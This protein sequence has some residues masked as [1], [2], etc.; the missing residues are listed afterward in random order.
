MNFRFEV[1]WEELPAFAM[2][3]W[4]TVWLSG[5]GMALATVTGVLFVL[6]LV[7]KRRSLQIPAQALVDAGR[8]I[9][10]L[11]LIYLIFYG[12]PAYGITLD[13][14][15][16]ALLSLVLYNTAY[17]A[18]IIRSAWENLP[19]GQ[20]EAARAF[21]YSGFNLLRR[22]TLPQILITASPVLGNQFIQV[23]KD[24]A[25]LAIITIPELTHT[26]R[27]VQAN[28]FVPF[29]SFIFAALVY[30]GLSLVIEFG[31]NQVERVRLIYAK[32]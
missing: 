12:L 19:P 1:I 31:V 7:S 10:F 22:I 24:S 9:P 28:Y 18:E 5:L 3:I 2:G 14:W 8:A 11:M 6:P 29:E 4:N 30:W 17:I 15:T 13:R 26:A 16:T 23:I 20:T 27:V 32:Y 21:G 25:F